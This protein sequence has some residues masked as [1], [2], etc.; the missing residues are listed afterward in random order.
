MEE[1]NKSKVRGYQAKYYDENKEAI[2]A[3]LADYFERE[4]E[5]RKEVRQKSL[6][7]SRSNPKRRLSDAI[8]TGIRRGILL[9]S[10][11]NRTFELLGYSPEQLCKHLERL[12]LPGMTWEN[13]GKKGWH[14]DHVVPLSVFNYETPYDADFKRAW[15]LDNLQPLWEKDNLS[16]NAK[17]DKPFQPNLLLATNDN[18][19][20]PKKE[21][22]IG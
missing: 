18:R 7:K 1:K 10:K 19:T 21:T 9:G 2:G 20:P 16:K 3:R 15:A 17:L 4:P 12:F 6:K 14:V 11:N 22:K 8:A 5:R 13:Y